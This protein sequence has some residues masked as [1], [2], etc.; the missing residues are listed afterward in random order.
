[1]NWTDTPGVLNHAEE[2]YLHI[3]ELLLS[4][5]HPPG[6][7]MSERQ[8]SEEL[9]MSRTPVREALKRLQR[10]GLVTAG[11]KGMGVV[12]CGLSVADVTHAYAY[13]A[14]LEAL[15]A[16][17]AAVRSRDGELSRA[18]LAELSARAERVQT[19][20]QEGDQRRA[21]VAN[22]RFHQW[23]CTLAANPFATEALT[24]LW[25]RIAVSSLSNL[26]VDSQWGHEVHGHHR[27]LVTAITEGDP[28]R[29]A[30]VARHHIRRAAV[31]YSG[32]HPRREEP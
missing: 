29:A 6:T 22:L 13:R 20:S 1:M 16:E 19:H 5:D 17:L 15:T 26:T 10:D 30:A 12:V 31:V 23:I 9:N 18:Q 2:A 4:G 7:Q 11:G 27:D 24:K 25:D 21:T 8:L 3:R 14:A 28:E 32:S